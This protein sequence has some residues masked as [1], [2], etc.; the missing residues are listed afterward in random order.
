[1]ISRNWL[2]CSPYILTLSCCVASN[3]P[4]GLCL[5]IWSVAHVPQQIH[6]FDAISCSLCFLYFVFF[7][8]CFC[9]TYFLLLMGPMSSLP[10]RSDTT[11][12]QSCKIPVPS[13]VN[14]NQTRDIMLQEV[15]L[16]SWLGNCL[17]RSGCVIVSHVITVNLDEYWMYIHF[18]GP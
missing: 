2:K 3:S 15:R 14:S 13:S 18:Y 7:T 4:F 17:A 1:M 8:P 5:F 11:R 12:S 9:P 6:C 16:S 10:C